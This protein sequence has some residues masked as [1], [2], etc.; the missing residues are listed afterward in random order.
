MFGIDIGH[1]EH[2]ALLVAGF[3]ILEP[4]HQ[5]DCRT[6]ILRL[7][8]HPAHVRPQLLVAEQCQAEDIGVEGAG[9]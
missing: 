5:R 2:Q 1:A 9:P 7:E 6:A 4:R 3:E 8:L